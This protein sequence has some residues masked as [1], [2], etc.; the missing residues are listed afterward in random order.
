[1]VPARLRGEVPM[2]V[3]PIPPLTLQ[4]QALRDLENYRYA[5]QQLSRWEVPRGY[6][7]AEGECLVYPTYAPLAICIPAALCA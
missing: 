1:M 3:D 2:P 7:V 4:Q 5:I 6:E